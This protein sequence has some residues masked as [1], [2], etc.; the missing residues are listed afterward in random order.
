MK[1]RPSIGARWRSTRSTRTR[2]T[3]SAACS[4]SSKFAEAIRE[5]Q[6]VVRL[7]PR[8]PN[9]SREPRV[10]LR[11]GRA[12]RAR[13]RGDRCRAPPGAAEPLASEL[14]R[15]RPAAAKRIAEGTGITRS[16]GAT[17]EN[18]EV[19]RRREATRAAIAKMNTPRTPCA[20]LD[21]SVQSA[22]VAGRPRSTRRR[23]PYECAQPPLQSRIPL[24]SARAARSSCRSTARSWRSRSS[25][26][27]ST[28]T[29]S[30]FSASWSRRRR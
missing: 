4:C 7:Q 19:R 18:G 2:T 11:G 29:I 16:N 5:Y 24:Y 13:G 6:E 21:R 22:G 28:S 25:A 23:R 14:R 1:P 20:H 27:S 30:C 3:I 8:V 15:Q 9:G 26:G 10:G 17:E 12:I